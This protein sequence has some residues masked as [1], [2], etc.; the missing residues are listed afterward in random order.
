VRNVR[1]W[2]KADMRKIDGEFTGRTG[3]FDYGSQGLPGSS[4]RQ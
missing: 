4:G 2:P 1:Y 3:S